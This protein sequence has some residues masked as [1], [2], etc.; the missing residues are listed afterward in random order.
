MNN[1]ILF[2]ICVIGL[3]LLG[4]NKTKIFIGDEAFTCKQNSETMIASG[5]FVPSCEKI[6]S[7][8]KYTIGLD[9]NNIAVYISSNDYNG[10]HCP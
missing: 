4:C 10:P 2:L 5:V 3:A 1:K 9:K 8:I 7:G 6:I